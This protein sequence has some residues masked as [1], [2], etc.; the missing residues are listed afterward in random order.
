MGTSSEQDEAIGS[1]RSGARIL[2]RVGV[3]Q[4]DCPGD[5][6]HPEL[7]WRLATRAWQAIAAAQ[8]VGKRQAELILTERR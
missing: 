4:G 8:W 2:F 7:P 3:R 6:H 5:T 1:V